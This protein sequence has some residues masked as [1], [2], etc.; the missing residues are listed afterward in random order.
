MRR[1]FHFKIKFE[2]LKRDVSTFTHDPDRDTHGKN[3]AVVF[4][5]AEGNLLTVNLGFTTKKGVTTAKIKNVKMSYINKTEKPSYKVI[6]EGKKQ[7]A[8][9]IENNEDGTFSISLEGCTTGKNLNYTGALTY[10]GQ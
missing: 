6:T 5:D 9:S 1:L 7:I 10:T 2:I 4:T 3:S 8:R